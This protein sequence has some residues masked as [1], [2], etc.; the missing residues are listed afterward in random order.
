[1]GVVVLY[2]GFC[3]PLFNNDIEHLFLFLLLSWAS[4]N[5]V[6]LVLL[7]DY[8]S[9]LAFFFMCFKKIGI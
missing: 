5:T 1:M 4:P 3:V 7:P 8:Q 6:F 9:G 2:C